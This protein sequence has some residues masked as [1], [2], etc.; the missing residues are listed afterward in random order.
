M[1]HHIGIGIAALALTL[2]IFDLVI[3]VSIRWSIIAIVLGPLSFIAGIVLTNIALYMSW[4][5]DESIRRPLFALTPYLVF[6]F[7]YLF[8]YYSDWFI[9]SFLYDLL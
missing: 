6:V 4:K 3:L 9:F 1:R 8:I 2:G 5:R 7:L